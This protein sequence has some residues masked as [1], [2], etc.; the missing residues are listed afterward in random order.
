MIA[1]I[2]DC[3]PTTWCGR[4]IALLIYRVAV[5]TERLDRAARRLQRRPGI[6]MC[7]LLPLGLLTNVTVAAHHQLLR[8]IGVAEEIGRAR[9]YHQQIAIAE[10]Y[11][12]IHTRPARDRAQEQ[13]ERS[14]RAASSHFV[15]EDFCECG[16][17]VG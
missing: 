7:G 5:L 11:V 16:L 4:V 14:Q 8:L 1:R 10:D 2:L 17:M 6:G 12:L 15:P 3:L 9:R 13:R